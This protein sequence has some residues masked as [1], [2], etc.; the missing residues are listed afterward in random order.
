MPIMA[1]I[2]VKDSDNT[3]NRTYTKVSAA[4]ADGTPAIWR[5][6]DATKPPVQRPRLEISS[7][8]NAARTARKVSIFYDY[9]VLRATAVTGVY[10]IVGRI[11]QRGG[12][13]VVPQNVDDAQASSATAQAANLLASTLVKSVLATGYAPTN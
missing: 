5:L 12:D 10:E 13:I 3:T 7:R 4:G 6:E 1:D 11:Q 9:P 8:W 2:T